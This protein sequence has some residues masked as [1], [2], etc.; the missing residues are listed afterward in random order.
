[1]ASFSWVFSVHFDDSIFLTVKRI[2]ERRSDSLE[3]IINTFQLII[4][5]GFVISQTD[6]VTV[7][8]FLT[9]TQTNM[10]TFMAKTSIMFEAI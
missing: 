4:E 6:N 3:L 1:M 7:A 8:G 5:E 9:I 2:V 10:D